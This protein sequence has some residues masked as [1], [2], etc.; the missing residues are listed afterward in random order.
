MIGIK[1]KVCIIVFIAILICL[2]GDNSGNTVFGD[3]KESVNPNKEAIY[4][5]LSNDEK[6]ADRIIIIGD[7]KDYPPYSFI[8]EN[9]N[10][11]GFNVELAK[12]AAEAMEFKVKIKLDVWSEVR[13]EL[14]SGRIN[15]IS[16]MSYSKDREKLYS[17]TT[18]TAIT[19]ADVL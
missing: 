5:V 9:G 14:E 11:T 7:N 8:D 19:S 18:K 1:R 2:L 4:K 6:K 15:V 17:F 10:L 16:G 12:A 13:N 3:N